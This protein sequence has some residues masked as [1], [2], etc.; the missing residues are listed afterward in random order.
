MRLFVAQAEMDAVRK[1]LGVDRL[2]EFER[3][4]E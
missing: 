3:K 4:S 2:A 1:E